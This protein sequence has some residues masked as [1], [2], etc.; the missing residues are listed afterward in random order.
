MTICDSDIVQLEEN[1]VLF[2]CTRVSTSVTDAGNASSVHFE[3][4]SNSDIDGEFFIYGNDSV[5]M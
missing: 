2:F 4:R 5:D 3:N 1:D